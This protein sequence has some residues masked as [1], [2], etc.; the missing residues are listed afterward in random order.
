MLF[1]IRQYLAHEL[2][3][4]IKSNYQV[5]LTDS[6]GA[7]FCGYKHFHGYELLRKTIKQN[8][9]RAVAR[10]ADAQTLA[11]HMSWAMHCDS[12]NLVNKLM[13]EAV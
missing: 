10:G 2:K 4:T 3:L 1:E 11:S 5:F 8:F 13:H 6:R 12:K 9:A 7:D